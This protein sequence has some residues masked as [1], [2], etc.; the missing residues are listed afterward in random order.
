MMCIAW[1]SY[2]ILVMSE[3][4]KRS[5]TEYISYDMFADDKGGPQIRLNSVKLVKTRK[6]HICVFLDTHS[7]PVGTMARYEQ[8]IVDGGWRGFYC[9]LDCMDKWMDEYE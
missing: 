1:S 5:V 2:S 7:I 3:T 4:M 6:E 9:C 8:G